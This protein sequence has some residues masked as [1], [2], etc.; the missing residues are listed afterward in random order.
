MGLLYGKQ[1]WL[2]KLPPY[3]GGGEMIDTVTFEKILNNY[4][5]MF[6]MISYISFLLVILGDQMLE[7]FSHFFPSSKTK[8]GFFTP[9]FNQSFNNSLAA[10]LLSLPGKINR[11]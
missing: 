5:F 8:T 7:G 11:I 1:E 2:E 4:K 6:K 3:Q 10:F 9:C